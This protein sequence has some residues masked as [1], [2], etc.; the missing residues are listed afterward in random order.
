MNK[1]TGYF[2][3]TIFVV[4]SL[5]MIWNTNDVPSELDASPIILGSMGAVLVSLFVGFLI[6][7]SY[8]PEA[9][10][11]LAT[12]IILL[13]ATIT[14]FAVGNLEGIQN[15]HF[16]MLVATLSSA[17]ILISSIWNWDEVFN[18]HLKMEKRKHE[19][20]EVLSNLE[21]DKL[22]VLAVEG[23]IEES[24][25]NQIGSHIELEQRRNAAYKT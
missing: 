20:F 16:A 9:K 10:R 25:P 21:D 19:S 17:F 8:I 2:A 7:G 11:M 15:Y 18:Q 3:F 6:H 23:S 5:V 24:D 4:L 13:A 14:G 22:S 1:N 12:T